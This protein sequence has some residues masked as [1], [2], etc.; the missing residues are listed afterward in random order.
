MDGALQ[1]IRRNAT[2]NRPFL[3]VV[4]FHAPHTPLVS[5]PPHSD[6]YVKRLD[7]DHRRH[8]YG[9]VSAM[10][11]EIGRLRACL[12]DLGIADNTLVWF[13]SDNGPA[14]RLDAPGSTGSLRGRK[15]SLFEGGVRVPSVL[16]WPGRLPR[17]GETDAIAVTS[18]IMPTILDAAGLPR[19]D[20]RPMDGTSLLPVILGERSQ[21]HRAIPFDFLDHLALI[22]PRYKLLIVPEIIEEGSIKVK[23]LLEPGTYLYDLLE[24][25]GEQENIASVRPRRVEQMTEVLMRWRT[26]CENSALGR[27]Y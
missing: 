21:V 11:E 15:S 20:D 12:R 18:D 14:N 17:R 3:A 19:I 22:E 7:D 5:G 26:S 9:S 8:Y 1:F 6:H 27:D 16:E 4:W 23:P 25:P 13:C 10:D 2:E 24:D